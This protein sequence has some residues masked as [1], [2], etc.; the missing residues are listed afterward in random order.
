[1]TSQSE[2]ASLN[3][4]VLSLD[5]NVSMESDCLMYGWREFHSLGAKQL[6]S[7][8]P[9]VLRHD[10]GM[11]SSPADVERWLREGLYSWRVCRI[12]PGAREVG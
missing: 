10:V 3:R 9:M 12:V 1:M 11:V 5:L 6:K 2:Y 4:W 7:Q 8:A